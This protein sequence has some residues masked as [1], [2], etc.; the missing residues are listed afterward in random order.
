MRCACLHKG[1]CSWKYWKKYLHRGSNFLF[2]KIILWRIIIRRVDPTCLLLVYWQNPSEFVVLIWDTW[3]LITSPRITGSQ[4]CVIDHPSSVAIWR[5]SS[6]SSCSKHPGFILIDHD[7]SNRKSILF[8]LV[9]K[10][11]K[12]RG[13]LTISPI[14][15]HNFHF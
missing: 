9:F 11:L 12:S 1:F 10:Q 13:L 14:Q 8:R 2:Q 15:K 5:Q 6:Y 7:N 3:V 4:S